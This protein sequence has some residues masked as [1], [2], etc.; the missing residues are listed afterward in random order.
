VVA[1]GS[2][3]KGVRRKS[4]GVLTGGRTCSGR[5]HWGRGQGNGVGREGKSRKGES[6]SGAWSWCCAV[7]GFRLGG[8][9]CTRVFAFEPLRVD[10]GVAEGEL[11]LAVPSW[12]CLSIS[13]FGLI[14]VLEGG[15]KL[16]LLFWE[17]TFC[18]DRVLKS[19]GAWWRGRG[20]S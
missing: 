16:G 20:S 4:R 17:F 8:V 5:F 3:G 7:H 1:R 6:W 12:L 15:C 10:F 18:W 11:D 13:A 14:G 9:W 19:R 2:Q